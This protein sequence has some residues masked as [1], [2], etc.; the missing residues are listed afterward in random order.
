MGIHFFTSFFDG[1]KET[2]IVVIQIINSKQL[3]THDVGDRNDS[4]GAI[5]EI[6][7]VPY[8]FVKC[9]N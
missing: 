3:T 5:S 1:I 7:S 8:R 2:L 9:S 4:M 6:Y